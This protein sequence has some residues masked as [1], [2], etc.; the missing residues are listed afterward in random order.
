MVA[1]EHGV[2]AGELLDLFWS[3]RRADEFDQ[4]CRRP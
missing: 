2:P 4:G 1:I 3:G